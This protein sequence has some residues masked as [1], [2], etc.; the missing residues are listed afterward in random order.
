VI[1]VFIETIGQFTGL[2]DKEW[3]EIWEGDIVKED[4]HGMIGVFDGYMLGEYS[5]KN[6]LEKYA[7]DGRT[8]GTGELEIIGNIYENKELLNK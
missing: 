2:R 8:P 6:G 7:S 1:E 3:K 5:W 4:K